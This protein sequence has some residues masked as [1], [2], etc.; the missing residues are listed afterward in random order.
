L[1]WKSSPVL[2]AMA[3]SRLA[4]ITS[5]F[6]LRLPVW[7]SFSVTGTALARFR[8]EEDA[9]LLRA[10]LDLYLP[11]H[12]LRHEQPWALGALLCLESS[13]H[14]D[15]TRD[16]L[17]KNGQWEQW[18]IAGGS[19]ADDPAEMENTVRGWLEFADDANKGESAG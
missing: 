8:E 2:P 5:A 16:L 9:R 13:L 10:Y 7:L 6:Q 1:L 17:G 14:S 3:W 4:T 12:E 11:R 15:F 18:A 19:C